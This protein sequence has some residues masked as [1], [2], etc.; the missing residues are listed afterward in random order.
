MYF[1][2]RKAD[3]RVINLIP[4]PETCKKWHVT[5]DGNGSMDE[6]R[7]FSSR[8]QKKCKNCWLAYTVVREKRKQG[9]ENIRRLK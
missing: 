4:G 5:T 3:G 9:C 7:C 2:V 1:K 6:I 8:R